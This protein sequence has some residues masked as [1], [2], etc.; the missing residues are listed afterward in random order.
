MID[1]LSELEKKFGDD[2]EIANLKQRRFYG[3]LRINFFDG[4]VAMINKEHTIK[5]TLKKGD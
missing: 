4:K 3:N 5:P 1:W 2:V